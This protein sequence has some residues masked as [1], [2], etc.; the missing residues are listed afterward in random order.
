[1]Y[2]QIVVPL[3]GSTFAESALPLALT[4]AKE[5]G[6]GIHLVTVLEP[7]SAF[8]YDGWEAP[9]KEWS[10]EYLDD[11]ARRISSETGVATTSAVV[12]GLTVE[13]LQGEVDRT[14]ADLV[15]TATHGRG[16]VSRLWLGSV[17]DSFVRLANRP[18][19]LVR[20]DE[21]ADPAEA[22]LG[23]SFATL[24]VPL[25]GSELSEE[26]LRHAVAFGELFDSAYHLTR[27]VPYPFETSGYV[28]QTSQPSQPL[29]D[30]IR[31]EAL[32]YLEEHADRLRKRGHRVTTSVAVDPQPAS[33]ILS[34]AEAVG[35]DM[36][37]MATHGRH[38]WQRAVLGSTADKVL[39]GTHAPLL[40]YRPPDEAS[41]S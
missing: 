2:A 38:G 18:V 28:P 33:G 23:F 14:R 36:V 34:E 4:A 17:A 15:V 19:V 8:A 21:K 29:V 37:A 3:D 20:P 41:L 5:T 30:E 7:V 39:R 24:L 6:A 27:V 11:V 40:L 26:A 16:A 32:D 10:S 9:A 13:A 22:A 31:R 12:E 1:M 25:D 35:V